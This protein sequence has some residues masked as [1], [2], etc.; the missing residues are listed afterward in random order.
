M[1]TIT[2]NLVTIEHHCLDLRYT[3]LRLHKKSS[4]QENLVSSIEQNGQL[5][6]VIIIPGAQQNWILI[7]G[8]LRL[9]ALKRLGADTVEAEVWQCDAMEALLAI[10][11][12]HS[13]RALE[14]FEEA[15]LLKE[16][17]TKHDLSQ[18]A[19]SRHIG[20]DPSWVNRRLALIEF[21]PADTLQA[22]S[23][24]EISLWVASRILA[25]LA[26]A[27]AEH[28]QMVL[29]YVRKNFHNTREMEAFYKHYQHSNRQERVNMVNKPALGVIE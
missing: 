21:L 27:N 6:P 17:H 23:N 16:L 4:A 14:V 19:L 8:Y 5:M 15:L 12:M 11:K 22:M 28:A 10:I 3:H 2:K 26:R 13:G 18:N 29:N 24:G 9:Q 7:D 25:P 20:R 1:A